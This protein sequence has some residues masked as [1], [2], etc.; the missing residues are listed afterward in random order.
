[1]TTPNTMPPVHPGQ[2]LAEEIEVRQL[3]PEALARELR[4]P[5]PQ[6]AA[7]L[8]A[9]APV[10][11]AVADKLSRYPIPTPPPGQPD[12]LRPPH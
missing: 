1:M 3:T 11:A 8:A 7:L 10:D 4:L 2:I 5:Q 9:T 12:L 6:V